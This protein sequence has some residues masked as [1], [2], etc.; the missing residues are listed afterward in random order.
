MF[1]TNTN[2]KLDDNYFEGSEEGSDFLSN[3]YDTNETI[4]SI[5]KNL[6][7]KNKHNSQYNDVRSKLLSHDNM[8][9]ITQTK[10]NILYLISIISISII[11]GIILFAIYNLTNGKKTLFNY[12]KICFVVALCLTCCLCSCMK[13]K[14]EIEKINVP[15]IS[16]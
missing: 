12:S 15:L 8:I 2:T 1:R 13:Y 4:D 7:N 5:N 10:K 14:Y 16:V 9:I 6:I 11:T 3:K